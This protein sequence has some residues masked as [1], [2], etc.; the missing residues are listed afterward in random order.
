MDPSGNVYVSD[1][2]DNVIRKISPEGAVTT[3]LGVA[4]VFTTDLEA[5]P[6]T[7]NPC[8]LAVDPASG[9]VFISVPNG[10]LVVTPPA[11]GF[12]PQGNQG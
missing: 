8:G 12:P 7:I 11:G 10:V 2:T 4:G 5:V 9:R 3:I 1:E 6:A